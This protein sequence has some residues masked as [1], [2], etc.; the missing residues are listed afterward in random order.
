MKRFSKTECCKQCRHVKLKGTMT[1]WSVHRKKQRT[2]QKHVEHQ[3]ATDIQ[4]KHIVLF[5]GVFY[6]LFL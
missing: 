1:Q 5:F 2:I 3:D 6:F 4:N